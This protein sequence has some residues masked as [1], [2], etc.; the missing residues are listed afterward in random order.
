MVYWTSMERPDIEHRAE[1]RRANQTTPILVGMVFVIAVAVLVLSGGEDSEPTED[2]APT[3][4][5]APPTSETLTTTRPP[6]P[7]VF[8]LTLTRSGVAPFSTFVR[9]PEAAPADAPAE[10]PRVGSPVVTDGRIAVLSGGALLVGRPG[11]PLTEL[12]C[13]YDELHPSNEPGHVWLRDGDEATLVELHGGGTI[14]ELPVG[15]DRIVGPGSFGLVTAGTDGTIRWR[16]PL[17]APLDVPVGADREA[18][19]GGGGLVLVSGVD[20]TGTPRWELRSISDGRVVASLDARGGWPRGSR[21]VLAADGETVAIPVATGWAVRAVPDMVEV[22]RLT[23]SMQPV[24]IGGDR[25][26]ALVGGHLV[27]SD[28][29]EVPAPAAAMAVA[30]Q[31]P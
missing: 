28:G 9:P 31:S 4:V 22:G 3:T 17:F 14:T 8:G 23:R 16:R 13:C 20:R 1:I 7:A 29:S 10:V 30:E 26:A 25:F 21:P 24:W 6:L 12:G 18:V 5:P 19:D 27:V 2:V 15:D 11:E